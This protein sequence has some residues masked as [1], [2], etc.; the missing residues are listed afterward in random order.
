MTHRISLR[1]NEAEY[2]A[3]R[4]A[5]LLRQQQE[6]ATNERLAT[7]RRSHLMKCPACGYDLVRGEWEHVVLDQCPHCHGVWID[8]VQAR[9]LLEHH[10]NALGWILESVMRGVAGLR[11]GT[12]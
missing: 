9:R 6:A 5:D 1:R 12:S 3:R 7:E 10:D 4:E 8:A 11:T 2:F